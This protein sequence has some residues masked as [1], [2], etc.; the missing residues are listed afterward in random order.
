MHCPQYISLCDQ[1][2]VAQL[3]LLIGAKSF[4]RKWW[5]H[6]SGVLKWAVGVGGGALV[7]EFHL[8]SFISSHRCLVI[9]LQTENYINYHA[10]IG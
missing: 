1:T 5:Q 2:V 3:D 6:L 4:L 8:L 9:H 10:E 7:E